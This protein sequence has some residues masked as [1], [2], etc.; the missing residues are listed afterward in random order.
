MA[1]ETARPSDATAKVPAMWREFFADRSVAFVEIA[2][3]STHRPHIEAASAAIGSVM[4]AM[5]GIGVSVAIGVTSGRWWLGVLVFVVLLALATL[6]VTA[7]RADTRTREQWEKQHSAR[8]TQDPIGKMLPPFGAGTRELEDP[9]SY[10][11]LFTLGKRPALVIDVAALS[12]MDPELCAKP[13]APRGRF[14]EPEFV[15]IEATQAEIGPDGALRADLLV[16]AG[17]LRDPKGVIWTVDDSVLVVSKVLARTDNGR[18]GESPFPAVL[19]LLVKRDKVR[20]IQLD[21]TKPFFKWSRAP[22]PAA[23]ADASSLSTAEFEMP[24]VKE[25]LRLLLSSWTYP[26]P[27]PDLAI[28]D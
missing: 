11:G 20:C 25:P 17:W 2:R 21:P 6:I 14:P 28:R 24:T 19:I 22:G 13:L 12:V 4:W 16:G 1:G 10:A 8:D 23:V 18:G 3:R 7:A 5:T 15:D 9:R 27:R 26:E